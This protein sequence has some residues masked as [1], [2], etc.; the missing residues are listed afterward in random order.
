MELFGRL[1][2]IKNLSV[3]NKKEQNTK[4][5]INK[6][7]KQHIVLAFNFSMLTL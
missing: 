1:L 7:I 5:I 2:K 4:K 3:I 6:R